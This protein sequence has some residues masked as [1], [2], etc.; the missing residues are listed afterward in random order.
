MFVPLTD[1][2]VPSMVHVFEDRLVI[3][4]RVKLLSGAGHVMRTSPLLGRFA[5]ERNGSGQTV[6]VFVTELLA[7]FGSRVSEPTE[8]T[9]RMF[10]GTVGTTVKITFAEPALAMS[11]ST[12]VIGTVLVT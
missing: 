3:E 9:L 7:K 5:M 12:P 2:D 8:A 6:V 10:P 11:P 4:S 1:R